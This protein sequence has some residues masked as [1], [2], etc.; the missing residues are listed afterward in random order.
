MLTGFSEDLLRTRPQDYVLCAALLAASVLWLAFPA[1]AGGGDP[2]AAVLRHDG[3][4][5]GELPL[6]RPARRVLAFKGGS[7]TLEV[8]PGRGVRVLESNCP[9]KVCVHHGWAGKTGET[10]VCL[11]NKFLAEIEGGQSE[12]DAVIR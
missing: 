1:G 6:D 9:A 11:P 12:Y 5:I 8:E 10:I 2:T 3:A 4:V 7:M